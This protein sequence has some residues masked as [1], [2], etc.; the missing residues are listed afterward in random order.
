MILA[1]LFLWMLLSIQIPPAYAQSG[2][3]NPNLHVER[4]DTGVGAELVTLVSSRT[5]SP[6][7]VISFLRDTLGDD[8]PSNDMIRDIWVLSYARP[9]LLQRIKASV[10]FFY[11]KS[12]NAPDT[13]K[14]PKP[15]L[16]YSS[17]R[18][19]TLTGILGKLF[20]TEF[21]DSNGMGSR[22][23]TRSYRGNAG[24]YRNTRIS[25]SLEAIKS[26]NLES[27]F[28]GLTVREL[29]RIQGRLILTQRLFGDLTSEDHLSTAK[30]QYEFRTSAEIELSTSTSCRYLLLGTISGLLTWNTAKPGTSTIRVAG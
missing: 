25:Q 27:G 6:E 18:R 10:P 15:I 17:T 4:L 26:S 14:P 22:A 16:D 28:P 21:L 3:A 30:E 19:R 1:A 7:P 12:G 20:Q 2:G 29:D 13:D 24:E 23:T 9:S 5:G 8:D 11:R